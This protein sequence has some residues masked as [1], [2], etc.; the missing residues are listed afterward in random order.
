[1][2]KVFY[3][4]GNVYENIWNLP[5]FAKNNVEPQLWTAKLDYYYTF[6]SVSKA[7]HRKLTYNVQ[8][9]C[10]WLAYHSFD[11]VWQKTHRLSNL[12]VIKPCTKKS[13][14]TE[15]YKYW[16]NIS[17]LCIHSL[18]TTLTRTSYKFAVC[19][20]CASFRSL[21]ASIC[22]RSCLQACGVDKMSAWVGT[23]CWIW[24]RL[25]G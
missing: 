9:W 2:K 5:A 23:S 21:H 19:W 3:F 1:M 25:Q 13:V 14:F 7:R 22:L 11:S 18:H 16:L 15:L 6:A 8:Y 24:Q 4:L 17:H 10:S 12:T 20:L